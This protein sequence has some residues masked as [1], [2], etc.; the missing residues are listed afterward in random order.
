MPYTFPPWVLKRL[1]RWDRATKRIRARRQPEFSWQERYFDQILRDDE[2][3]ERYRT[4]IRENP[5]RWRPPG[6][7]PQGAAGGPRAA[8]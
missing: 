7:E 5:G 6:S 2:D 1:G 4:Y 3:L 8:G